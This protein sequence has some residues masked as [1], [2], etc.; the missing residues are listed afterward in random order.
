MDS[1][2]ELNKKA[3]EIEAIYKETLDRL[4]AIKEEEF[5]L[6]ADF[7]TALRE[8]RLEELKGRIAGRE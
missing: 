5:K 4:N 6:I 2:N 3:D 1:D 8:K 7:V